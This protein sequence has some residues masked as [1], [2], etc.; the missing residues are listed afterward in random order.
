MARE[1]DHINLNP[2]VR[3]GSTKMAISEDTLAENWE[4]TFGQH[5]ERSGRVH[6]LPVAA[7]NHPAKRTGNQDNTREEG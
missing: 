5:T 1:V 3:Q 6:P 2:A 4:R 7:E